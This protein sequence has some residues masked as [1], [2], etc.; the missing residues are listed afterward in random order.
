MAAIFDNVKASSWFRAIGYYP[1]LSKLLQPLIPK[2]LKERR[3]KHHEMTTAKVR[4]RQERKT[5][6]AD[7]LAGF[8]VEGADVSEAE[9]I[10]TARTLIIAGSET[11]ATLLSG[12]TFLL[13]KHPDVMRKL[14]EEVRS[15]FSSESEINLIGANKLRYMLACLDEAMRMY[16]PVPGSFPRD[17]PSTSS[18]GDMV[19]DRYIPEKV[20]S[21]NTTM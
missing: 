19:G 11:T 2:T 17:V 13:L 5:E 8:L 1:I 14:V 3:A 4:S 10:A 6:R 12:I 15:T 18:G 20:S 16:P 9:M 7:F 21:Q